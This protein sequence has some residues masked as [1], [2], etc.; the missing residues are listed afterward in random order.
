[1]DTMTKKIRL[2]DA[3]IKIM[4]DTEDELACHIEANNME[5]KR[6]LEIYQDNTLDIIESILAGRIVKEPITE[7]D[8]F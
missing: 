6:L 7:E 5:Y 1:M 3:V 8:L 2:I 4:N